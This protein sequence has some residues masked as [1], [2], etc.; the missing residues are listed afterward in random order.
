L[1]ILSVEAQNQALNNWFKEV[2][3]SMEVVEVRR[4]RLYILDSPFFLDL[5]SLITSSVKEDLDTSWLTQVF[6]KPQNPVIKELKKQDPE[7]DKK[8]E[9]LQQ[10]LFEQ[11]MLTKALKRQMAEMKE[12]QK[13]HEEAQARRSEALEEAV[14]KQSEDLKAM[15]IDMMTM[16]KKQ[17][18][19]KIHTLIFYVLLFMFFYCL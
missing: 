12:E 16:M 9:K 11:K 5:S 2:I 7:E 3:K 4:N 10:E 13:A 6:I 17:Q 18:Q 15:I 1:Q 19:P 8:V 14:K